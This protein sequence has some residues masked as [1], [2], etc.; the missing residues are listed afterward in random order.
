MAE[1]NTIVSRDGAVLT[2]TFNRP[3][4]FNSLTGAMLTDLASALADFATDLDLRV[5]LIR[6][7]GKYFSAGMDV[8]EIAAVELGEGPSNYRRAYRAA[9]WHDLW[10]ALETVEKPVVVAHQGDCMGAGLE[11]SLSCDFRLASQAAKY[12]LP[13]LNMGMIPGSGGTSRLVRIAGGALARWMIM[14]GQ[15]IDASQALHAGLI[16]A[17]Y[18]AAS[19]EDDVRAFCLALA[20]QPPEAMAAAKLA[21]EFATDLDRAQARNMERLVNSSLSGGAEQKRV[22]AKLMERFAPKG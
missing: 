2:F 11:M 21:I 7:E 19:F 13:E 14:A 9:A 22:F 6:A 10:D 17:V 18:P 5:L 1:S 15:T 4:K 12:A 16:N 8:N 20:A 3:D